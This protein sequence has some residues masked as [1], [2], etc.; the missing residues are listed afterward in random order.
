MAGPRPTYALVDDLFFRARIETTAE[1]AGTAVGFARSGEELPEGIGEALV[2]V[3]LGLSG[4]D[5]VEAIRTLAER[6]ERPTVV[7]FGP[8]RDV[9]RFAAA[10]KAGADRVLARS[11]FV[12]KLPGLLGARTSG[13]DGTG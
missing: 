8:H 1:A 12:E 11:A 2:I 5:P 3:D 4:E 7:A 6:P 10:R 13:D 9:E